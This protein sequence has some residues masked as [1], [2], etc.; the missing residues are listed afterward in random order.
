VIL[1]ISNIYRIFLCNLQLKICA[2][3][4]SED[5]S[6][7][8]QFAER[9]I[10]KLLEGRIVKC[11][12]ASVGCTVRAVFEQISTHESVCFHREVT[13][14]GIHRGVCSMTMPFAKLVTH[15]TEKKCAVVR[16]KCVVD[17]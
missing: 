8:N 2:Y 9:L 15:C 11:G 16:A 6:R 17:K 4:R 14:L 12:N 13:C 5:I 10:A 1:Y 7:R 3:C